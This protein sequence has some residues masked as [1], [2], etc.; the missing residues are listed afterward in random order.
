M[1]GPFLLKT[2]LEHNV[3]S[4]YYSRAHMFTT[5]LLAF[6]LYLNPLSRRKMFGN[7]KCEKFYNY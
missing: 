1:I 7:D 5:I 6:E 3:D 2:N 4:I